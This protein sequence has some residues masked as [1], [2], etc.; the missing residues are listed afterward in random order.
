M[1]CRLQAIVFSC[2]KRSGSGN[3]ALANRGCC[4]SL[5]C[6]P[7]WIKHPRFSDHHSQALSLLNVCIF[8][9]GVFF[10]AVLMVSSTLG[11]QPVSS[12]V[13]V[14]SGISCHVSSMALAFR[15]PVFYQLCYPPQASVYS[16]DRR[17][18]HHLTEAFT[19]ASTSASSSTVPTVASTILL[20]S[21]YPLPHQVHRTGVVA[22]FYP[23][24]CCYQC[25][26]FGL[27]YH[28]YL[29]RCRCLN[30]ITLIID[31]DCFT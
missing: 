4:C 8:I 31:K 11:H 13:V 6:F 30:W 22:F 12:G 21:H 14:I 19:V 5:W 20:S 25:I 9:F 26:S 17:Q 18:F 16:W 23:S 24:E 10:R 29:H 1:F 27:E 7:F 15:S 3:K 28:R 2:L